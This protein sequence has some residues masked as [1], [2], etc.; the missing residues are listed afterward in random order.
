M[1]NKKR[2]RGDADRSK[3]PDAGS[4]DQAEPDTVKAGGWVERRTKMHWR[5]FAGPRGVDEPLRIGMSREAYAE[6]CQHAK[7]SLNVEVCGVLIG[8]FCEDEEGAWVSVVAIV[9]GHAA[10]EHESH[11]SFSQETWAY[12]H[13]TREKKFAKHEIVGWYHTHPGFGVEFSEM[14]LFIQRNFF[15]GRLQFAFVTDPLGGDEAICVAAPHGITYVSRFW[16]DGRERRC[17]VP[18]DRSARSAGV[19]AASTSTERSLRDVEERL[20]QL[21]RAMDDQRI[22]VL[23][24]VMLLGMLIGAGM[25]VAVGYSLYSSYARPLR[26]PETVHWATVPVRVED[27]TYLMGVETVRWPMPDVME[28]LLIKQIEDQLKEEERKRLELEQAGSESSS[29]E[30][31]APSQS[32][33]RSGRSG[34]SGGESPPSGHAGS[35]P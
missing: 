18:A 30:K 5:N 21:I 32:N 28:A 15:S 33:E 6:L 19:A 3:E 9:R 17:L 2:K 35:K 26:P 31:T 23:R 10:K 14:D 4:G 12:I 27:K 1:S 13:E 34:G 11:V 24:V 16:V 22:V 29:G 8:D 25:V 7:E 20:T